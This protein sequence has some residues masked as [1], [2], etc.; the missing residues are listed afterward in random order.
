MTPVSLS[1]VLGLA[2]GLTASLALAEVLSIA[3]G[4]YIV[5]GYLAL[6][7]DQPGRVLATISIATAMTA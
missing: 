1:V 6:N 7:L 3:P 4:G 2:V 5:P